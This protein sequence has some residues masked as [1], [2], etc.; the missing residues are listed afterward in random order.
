MRNRDRLSAEEIEQ[1]DQVRLA[2]PDIA[3][4]CDLAR[5]FTDLVRNRRGQ[6]LS[7]WIRQAEQSGLVSVAKFAAFL[8]QDLDAVTAGL[9]LE[10]SSG[11]VEGHVNRV[12][13]IKRAN[14]WTGIVPAPPDTRPHPAVMEQP[15]GRPCDLLPQV[16]AVASTWVHR[17]QVLVKTREEATGGRTVPT[18]LHDHPADI[19]TGHVHVPAAIELVHR[20][21]DG[22]V[23]NGPS[24]EYQVVLVRPRIQQA[25]SRRHLFQS[26]RACP[27]VDR[28]TPQGTEQHEACQLRLVLIDLR[29]RPIRRISRT[30]S[31]ELRPN[32]LRRGPLR[33]S[34]SGQPRLPCRLDII[35]RTR[36][37]HQ[38]PPRT[39]STVHA[40]AVRAKFGEQFAEV[41]VALAWQTPVQAP[42]RRP[43]RSA[44]GK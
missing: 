40:S 43:R 9:T 5:A 34:K 35:H 27:A 39:R 26:S 15:P 1:L 19:R 11:I 21:E 33:R 23:G 4:T 20:S 16:R 2:C 24:Q 22:F 6:L 13:T 7:N 18:R 8:R 10:W 17:Q 29:P 25:P 31:L 42:P 32:R 44:G 30:E 38:H 41:A 28:T 36:M 14:V 37:P 3:R 12:K